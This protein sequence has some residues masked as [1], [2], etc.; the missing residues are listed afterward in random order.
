M[1]MSSENVK[2]VSE[3]AITT[4]KIAMPEDANPGNFNINGG[5]V[6]G[7]ID[8]IAGIVSLRHC[9]TR[10]VTASIDRM[11]FLYPVKIGEL[12]IFKSSV[13]CIFNTS[14]E[15]GVVVEVENIMTGERHIT[16]RA[17]LTFVAINESGKPIKVPQI[18]PTNEN[19][20]R[21]QKEAKG[22]RKLRLEQREKMKILD[23]NDEK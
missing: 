6:L 22:R 18:K 9:R 14:M 21:R 20:I 7:F 19:E 4:F 11:D 23:S 12:M 1:F 16:G 13:N 10:T 17:Y 8:D 2:L 15:I 5:V 3:S